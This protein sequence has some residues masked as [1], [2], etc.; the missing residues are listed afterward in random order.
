M[1]TVKNVWVMCANLSGSLISSRWCQYC[2]G[3]SGNTLSFDEFGPQS[4]GCTSDLHQL[5]KRC[6]F[7]GADRHT[8]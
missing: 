5:F 3:N 2:G 4:Q 8:L 6:T 7:A 1:K